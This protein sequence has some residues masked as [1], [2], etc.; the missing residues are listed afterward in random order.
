V[1]LRTIPGTSKR[2]GCCEVCDARIVCDRRAGITDCP[3][4]DTPYNNLTGEREHELFLRELGHDDGRP[5][6]FVLPA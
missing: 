4:C 5:V 3:G 2:S 1:T 6:V